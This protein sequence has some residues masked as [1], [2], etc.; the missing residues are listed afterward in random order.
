MKYFC[1]SDDPDVLT[2]MR[3]A[4]IA[5]TRASTPKEVEAAVRAACADRSV[6]ILLVTD[7]CYVMC[8]E[9]IDSLKLNA[10]RPLVNVIADSRGRRSVS[11]AISHLVSEA[12]GIK[13]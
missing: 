4:G 5:G 10:G 2:G 13:I 3:L 1:V 11:D 6:A 9:L 7:G 8:R 12:I